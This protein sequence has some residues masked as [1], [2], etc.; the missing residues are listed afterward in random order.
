MNKVDL[1]KFTNTWYNPAGKAK[2]IAWHTVNNIFFKPRIH[3]PYRF[4]VFLLRIFGAKIEKT[5][6]I[7]PS[8]NIKYPWFLEA[9]D[10]VWIGEGSWI[11]NLAKIKIGNNVCLSQR[12]FLCCGNHDYKSPSFDLIVKEIEIEDG[13]WIGAGAIVLGGVKCGSHSVL[14]AGSIATR[15]LEPYKIY[16][17]NP[18][19]YKRERIIRG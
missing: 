3:Y 17:G 14:T 11:D 15:D 9:G 5:T 10:N 13:V 16:Q 1:G 12:S 18:A 8:V 2:K 6:V 7:K 4:K 19:I